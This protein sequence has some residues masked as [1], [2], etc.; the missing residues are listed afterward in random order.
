MCVS[1]IENAYIHDNSPTYVLFV[2][3][4]YGERLGNIFYLGVDIGRPQANALA[5]WLV[6]CA[7]MPFAVSGVPSITRGV[8]VLGTISQSMQIPLVFFARVAGPVA[9]P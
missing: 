4:D 3:Q 2:R 1:S 6:V 5:D 9:S 7:M 8:F